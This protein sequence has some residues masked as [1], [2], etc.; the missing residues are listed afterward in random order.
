MRYIRYIA[1]FISLFVATSCFVDDIEQPRVPAAECDT[2]TIAGRITR[3][4]DHHV[5]TRAGK[6]NEESY[7]S[8]M[9]MAIFPITSTSPATLGEC[10]SYVHLQGSNVNFTVDRAKLREVYGN[11][12][13]NIPFALYLFANM[14]ELPATMDELDDKSLGYFMSKAYANNGIR[15]PQTGFPMVGSLGDIT[16]GQEEFILIPTQGEGESLKI[17]LPT[18]GSTPSDYIPIPLQ[19]LYAKMSFNIKLEPTQQIEQGTAPTFTLINYTLHNVP[20]MVY[21]NESENKDHTNVL[22]SINTSMNQSVTEGGVLTFDFY[23]P[24]RYLTPETSAEDYEY[25]M[26]EG[27]EKVK[28][29]SNVRDEDKKFCQRFKSKL[30]DEEQKATYI[31]LHGLYLDHQDHSW[32]VTYEIYLGENNYGNF[33]FKRNTNYINTVT[34]RGLTSY[35]DATTEEYGPFIDHRVN[36]VRSLPIIINVQR[37]TLLDSHYE[38]RPLRIRYPVGEGNTMPSNAQVKVE[39][40]NPDG[41]TKNIPNWIRMEHNNGTG[42][43]TSTHLASGKRK[44]F[45]TDL[46]SSTLAGNTSLTRSLTA[47]TNETFWIYVDQCNEG[48]PLSNKNKVRKALVK[49]SYLINGVVQDEPMEYMFCQHL[50]YPV[51]TTRKGAGE[52]GS[53]YIYYIEYEEE[54]L[55]NYDSE[56]DHGITEQAGMEWG[57]NNI[58][59]SSIE[60]A[61]II[62]HSVGDSGIGDGIGDFVSRQEKAFNTLDQRPKYD[63]YLY[64]DAVSILGTHFD[65]S[66]IGQKTINGRTGKYYKDSE[67]AGAL[68]LQDFSGYYLNGVIRDYLK[69][70]Y[71]TNDNAKIE[72]ITLEEKPKSAFA[73]CYNR[74]KRKTN[75]DV[76][77]QDWYLPAID[78]IEDIMEF[79]YGD[80]GTQFQDNMYW[81]CQPAYLQVDVALQRYNWVFGWN[82]ISGAFFY[83]GY[84]NDDTTHAR[85]TKAYKED[86]VFAGVP[87]SGANASMTRSG[88]IYISLL[89][90]KNAEWE[91][92]KTT[93]VD[94][95]AGHEGNMPRKDAKARVRCV[96]NPSG[97]TP[98]N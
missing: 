79:A 74:N 13:D 34:I 31:T 14:P 28:G 87:S 25:N 57:L 12:Y 41:T 49:V 48:A 66:N 2:I 32:D 5:D 17:K 75:G 21:A 51:Q 67:Y 88:K 23:I 91:A 58:Q 96:R 81:S 30:V 63:F 65:A 83:G 53:T 50:L 24:E 76:D 77:T 22:S 61:F 68:R 37:E 4:D 9:A 98:S 45:T 60:D 59:L 46:V 89:T 40:L 39:I 93:G 44:Y 29:Y 8:S 94:P 7:T 97:V 10:I 70:K 55:H 80:F 26:G 36:V 33:D 69:S 62:T 82:Q 56:D 52:D 84:F 42:A 72:G 11:Q 15:R 71:A 95:Y 78:E 64:R 3:Y 27:N 43:A 6:T 54:Y 90:S 18:L 38:V 1:L 73:Y 47:N 85:A 92:E 16:K 19:A 35:S 20:S 86:G